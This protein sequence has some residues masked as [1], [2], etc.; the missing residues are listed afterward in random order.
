VKLVRASVSPPESVAFVPRSSAANGGTLTRRP[1][2]SAKARRVA[3]TT[4]C[5]DGGSWPFRAAGQYRQAHGA[6]KTQTVT[7]S[8]D[9]SERVT[10]E[11]GHLHRW[12]NSGAEIPPGRLSEPRAT[13]PP[14][15]R[16]AG[17]AASLSW[18][19]NSPAGRFGVAGRLG[20][21]DPARQRPRSGQADL[22]C[23]TCPRAAP[24]PRP[25]RHRCEVPSRHRL[26][27]AF[28]D[29]ALTI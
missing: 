25:L 13:M 6:G 26:R 15:P 9:T 1:P 2:E 5:S 4:S 10:T 3:P 12:R 22:A 28:D 18:G 11:T 19:D 7:P 29:L 24:P 16:C 20:Y 21:R 8:S 23:R 17:F 27:V 14:A